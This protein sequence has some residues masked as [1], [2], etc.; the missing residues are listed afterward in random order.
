MYLSYSR[1]HQMTGLLAP[2]TFRGTHPLM[3]NTCTSH[4]SRFG[5]CDTLLYKMD[6]VS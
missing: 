5:K 1:P 3:L 4:Q 2:S 6:K